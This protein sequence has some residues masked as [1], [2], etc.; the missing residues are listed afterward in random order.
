MNL[1]Q[2]KLPKAHSRRVLSLV[3]EVRQ[4]GCLHAELLKQTLRVH[5]VAVERIKLNEIL[6]LK[7]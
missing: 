2:E 3:N 4:T 6:N 5:Y 7:P 1:N